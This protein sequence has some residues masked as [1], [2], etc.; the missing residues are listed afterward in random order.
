L[1]PN[2]WRDF[3]LQGKKQLTPNTYAFRFELPNQS[4]PILPVAS[5]LLVKADLPEEGSDKP[6]AVIRPYTPVDGG[7]G[8]LDLIVKVYPTGK[9]SKHI[10]ELKE[11]E[12]LAFKGPLP[13]YPYK[14]NHK[15][16]IG[17]IAGGSGLTPMLQVADEVLRN[18]DD[19]TQVS[20]IFANQSEDDII[21]KD[22]LDD[23][24][25]K[26]DNFRVYY[27]VDKPKWGGVFWKG[28]VGYIN[29]DIIEKHMPPP[30]DDNLIMVCGP[31]PLYK[32]LSGDK[33]PDKT[34]GPLTGLLKDMGYTESQVFK[35]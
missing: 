1:D 32:A 33:A 17:L 25:A 8:Y 22:K 21:L 34:Q 12:T 6:K 11:G 35:F 31:P 4:E 10:G 23:M 2:E 26:H 7:K 28:G 9:M 3:K 16:H 29:R 19:K 14:A 15:K 30:S 18:P 13:K 24:A 27:M 20:F 5:C